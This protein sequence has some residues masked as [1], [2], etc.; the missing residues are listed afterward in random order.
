MATLSW[1]GT[2]KK[3]TL[4]SALAVNPIELA[5]MNTPQRAEL[6]QFFR[7]QYVTRLRS[8]QRAGTTGYA[9]VKLEEDMKEVRDKMG[10]NMN[11]LDLVVRAK[12]KRRVLGEAYAD[13]KNPQ[14]ALATYVTLMQDF[15]SAK[16]STVKGW[17]QIGEEQDRRLFGEKIVGIRKG[18]SYKNR[19]QIRYVKDIAHRMSDEERIMFWKVYREAYRSD[20]V[21]LWSYSSADQKEFASKWMAGD[22]NHLDFEEAYVRMASLLDARPDVLPEHAGGVWGDPT[23]PNEE[24]GNKDYDVWG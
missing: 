15:F 14:N 17:R 10:I 9:L 1:K 2:G 21:A 12:G 8:F 5:R 13:R 22:F 3:W 18:R 16:S 24:G 23:L 19:T 11:P 4:K 7:N 6:A 20:W